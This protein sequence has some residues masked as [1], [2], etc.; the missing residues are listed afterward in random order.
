M[1]PHARNRRL[2]K[3]AAGALTLGSA[4]LL[5]ACTSAPASTPPGGLDRFYEQRIAW[6]PC[7][8]YATTSI[9]TAVFAAAPAAECGRLMVPLNYREPAGKTARLAVMRVPARGEAIGSLVINPGGPGGPG[10]FAAAATS[11]GHAKTPL[12]ESFDLVGLD[13]RG[14]GKS[15]PAIDCFSDAEADEGNVLLS[16]QGTTVQWTEADTRA[17]VDRC[18]ER[19]GGADVLAGVGTRDAARDVDVLRA[20]LGDEKLTFLGQ[21]YGTR[22]GAVYAEQFPQNVRAMLLDGAI[23]PHQGTS[24][25]RIGAFAGFQRSFE[26]MAA[27]CVTQAV[28]PLGHDPDH[29]TET[30]HQIVRPLYETP[31]PALNSELSYDEAIG[32]VISGLYT[33]AAWPRVI[34]GIAQLPQGRGDELLQLNYDFA[35]RDAEG[36]WTNFTEALY[37]INCMDEERLSETEGDELRAA[38]FA[39]APFMDPGVTLTGARDGCEHWPAEPTL[40]YPYATDIAD[41]PAT[42]VVS[43]TGDPTTPHAGGINLAKTLGSALLTVEGEGHTI[44]T[45]GTNSCVNAIAADYLIHLE[46]PPAGSSCQL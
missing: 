7:E 28:C 13:P 21:S 32:G 20:V 39:A 45:A 23:D 14:V 10:L 8:D 9:E 41:L 25:R 3:K 33:E 34:A 44:V 17:I 40:G 38:I 11:L 43:I 36:R 12:T 15:E 30:F 37:A 24:E 4:V 19:S 27:F 42:L 35:L 16:T 18:A 31:V 5:T 46:L 2:V 22:L 1:E 29:A 6:E 26:E